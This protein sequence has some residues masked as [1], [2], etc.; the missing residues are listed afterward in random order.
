MLH[1]EGVLDLMTD[2]THDIRHDQYGEE[3]AQNHISLIDMGPCIGS[4]IQ[5]L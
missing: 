2:H 3:S 1:R 5:Y 4:K